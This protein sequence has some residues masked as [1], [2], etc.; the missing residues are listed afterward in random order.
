[1]TAGTTTPHAAK[2]FIDGPDQ[3][4]LLPDEFQF[5]GEEVF[6]RRDPRTGEVVLSQRRPDVEGSPQGEGEI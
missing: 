5:E 4:V 2:L 3:A 6:I 1:V